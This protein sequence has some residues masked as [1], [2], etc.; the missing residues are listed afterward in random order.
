[1]LKE[2]ITPFQATIL[3]VHAITPTSILVVPTIAIGAAGQDAWMTIILAWVCSLVC[4]GLYVSINRHNPGMPFIAFLEKRFGRAV[5]VVVG[6][7]LAQYYFSSLT[8][9]VRE[10]A[11]FLSDKVLLSTPMLMTGAVAVFVGMYSA[12]KGVEVI[13]RAGILMF[14]VGALILVG[15]DLLEIGQMN[16][17][18]LTPVAQAPANH[19]VLGSM[20]A[21]GWLS[22]ASVLLLL[23]PYL[24][25]PGK[26]WK[27]GFWGVTLSAVYLMNAVVI[28]VLVFGAEL[29]T[30][31]TYPSSAASEIIDYDFVERVDMF[32]IFAWVGTVYLKICVFAF[33]MMHCFQAVFKVRKEK[34]FHVSLGVV[35]LLTALYSWTSN[36]YLIQHQRYA[37]TPFLLVLNI[38]L[39]L[40]LLVGVLATNKRK[41]PVQGG[42]S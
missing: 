25:K 40:L 41:R 20:P 23:G 36:V 26:A 21:I 28:V 5:G 3:I 17:K 29:P 14:V 22:E 31:M 6:L 37:S 2:R 12:A 1:M 13:A 7:V 35:V 32:F 39:P 18:F 10:L 11:D 27:V 8:T 15:S 42:T 4:V 33:G 30:M 19:V 38:A 34:P 9:I 16:L 24:T